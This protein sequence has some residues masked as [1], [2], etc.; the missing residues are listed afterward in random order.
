[1]RCSSCDMEKSPLGATQYG[2]YDL[3]NDCLLEFTLA[4][5]RGDVENVAEYM[6]QRP[7]DP[8]AQPPTES[9]STAARTLSP[10]PL[11]KRSDKLMPSNEPC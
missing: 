11:P 2:A 4:L 3:C 8:E 1:M 6:T 10:S 7:D 9:S 5:A